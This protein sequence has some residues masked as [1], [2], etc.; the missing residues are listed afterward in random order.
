MNKPTKIEDWRKEFSE[1][2]FGW[3]YKD[4]ASGFCHLYTSK[5]KKFISEALSQAKAEERERIVGMIRKIW[6]KADL[7]P[8]KVQSIIIEKINKLKQ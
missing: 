2:R 6:F 3:Y 7:I 4:R 1:E 8:P 5:I